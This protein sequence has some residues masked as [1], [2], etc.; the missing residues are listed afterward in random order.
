MGQGTGVPDPVPWRERA[1]DQ[2]EAGFTGPP[3]AMLRCN[4]NVLARRAQITHMHRHGRV[5]R[6]S[7][8]LSRLIGTG[9]VCFLPYRIAASGEKAPGLDGCGHDS[10][11]RVDA[12]SFRRLVVS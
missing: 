5:G 8:R 3:A 9:C 4:N 1:L 6:V 10:A 12:S 2:D 11:A 7:I